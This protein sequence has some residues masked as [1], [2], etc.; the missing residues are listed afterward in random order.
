MSG[1]P[2]RV[3]VG[4]CGSIAAYK[5]VVLVRELVRRGHEATVVPTRAALEFVGRP[6]FE[7][8]SHHAVRVDLFERATE[9]SHVSMGRG[10]DLMIVA[11]ATA[12]F[13]ARAAVGRADDLLSATMLT[14]TAPIVMA[15]AMH[16]EMWRNAAT[17]A[18]VATLRSRGISIIEPDSGP[19]TGADSGVGRLPD[20]IRI[21]DLA[22]GVLP[23][24]DAGKDL[25][26]KRILITAGGTREA[27]DPVRFLGNFS[28]GRQ[29][30]GFAEAAAARGARVT[31]IAANLDV[32][33]P[34]GV[35][36]IPVVS[37]EDLA[38]EVLG[39]AAG[40]D[41]VVMAAAVAD[42]RPA[43]VS[44]TKLK[45]DRLGDTT[46]L[47]LVKN[48]DVLASLVLS[49]TVAGPIVGFAAETATGDEL[50]RLGREKMARKKC[51]LL[52]VNQVGAGHGFGTD[53][54]DVVV[55]DRGG[56]VVL[57]ASGTKREIAD[58]VLDLLA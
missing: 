1:E 43:S 11:P 22:L 35:E 29:G 32:D 50:V 15:P 58:A 6:T 30:V 37:A 53:V 21:V 46:T 7:A 27:L 54:N 34:A 31:L 51:D 55:L 40:M 39:R 14:T 57:E 2:L 24:G 5:A 23:G 49:R 42:Y 45:K 52:V 25:V 12:D 17:Q 38:R 48:R 20:P 19:L 33:V 8:V 16:T 9:V 10:A 56:A 26:G 47:R 41:A 3:I 44:G 18:N 13:L 28:S 36:A 4:V